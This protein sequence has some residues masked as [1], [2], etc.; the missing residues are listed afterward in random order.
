ML[1]LSAFPIRSLC[2]PG[3]EDQSRLCARRGDACPSSSVRSPHRCGQCAGGLYVLFAGSGARWRRRGRRPPRL[4]P[5]A[6]QK[7]TATWKTTR[8]EHLL[9]AGRRPYTS[10]KGKK[11]LTSPGGT[12]ENQ[13]EKRNRGGTSRGGERD[14]HP[15][16]PP[17]R[18]PDQL[19]RWD[20]NVAE[21]SSWAAEGKAE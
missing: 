4:L 13:R 7:A 15:G 8:P 19:R 18:P 14:P 12:Q 9:A 3:R 16:K 6:R 2:L 11:P 17:D 20:L 21:N 10:P 5:P 1:L